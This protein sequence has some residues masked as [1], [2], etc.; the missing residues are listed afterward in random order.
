MDAALLLN[1]LRLLYAPGLSVAA[2]SRLLLCHGSLDRVLASEEHGEAIGLLLEARNSQEDRVRRSRDALLEWLQASAN[3]HLLLLE[4]PEYPDLLRQVD[5]APPFITVRGALDSFA[6]PGLAVVGSRRCSIYGRQQALR[7][8]RVLGMAGLTIYSGLARGIDAAAHQGALAVGART[9]AVM[10][11]GQDLIY[12]RS[13]RRLAEEI[14]DRGALVSEFPPGTPALA[15]HFPRR[16]RL[17]SGLS[18]GTLVVEASPRSGSLITARLA[19]EQ[20]REVF[21]LPGPVGHSNSR[22]CH[23]LIRSG[24]KLVESAEDILEELQLGSDDARSGKPEAE[25]V[26]GGPDGRE[27]LAGIEGQVMAA[28]QGRSSTLEALGV[29]IGRPAAEL[30]GLLSAMEI[31]GLIRQGGGRVWQAAADDLPRQGR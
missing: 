26:N 1:Y 6:H 30:P 14:A 4:D 3:H 22:G 16:N 8:S 24:A 31:R 20:N 13:N 5:S 28:L 15:H 23:R 17:I 11:T 18:L 27:N 7:L 19:L 29:S 9:V 2:L 10:A 12:P 21:A 25:W